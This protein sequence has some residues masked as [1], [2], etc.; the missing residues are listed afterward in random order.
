M[1]GRL[2]VSA[3]EGLRAA[4]LSGKEIAIAPDWMF[5]PEL[6]SGA[7]RTVLYE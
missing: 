3:S 5:A 1:S 2:R 7:V 4:V 6:A